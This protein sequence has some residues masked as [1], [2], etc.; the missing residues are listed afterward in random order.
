LI[1]C[2]SG[3]DLPVAREMFGGWINGNGKGGKRR[4]LASL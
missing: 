4:V 1:V 3:E 2:Y